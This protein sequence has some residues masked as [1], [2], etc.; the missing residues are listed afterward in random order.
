MTPKQKAEQL[1]QKIYNIY[2]YYGTPVETVINTKRLCYACIDEVLEQMNG[3]F[4][5]DWWEQVR[6]EIKHL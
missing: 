1:Y 3:D 5:S 2:G 6:E 4:G